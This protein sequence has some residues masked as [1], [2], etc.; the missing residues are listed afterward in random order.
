MRMRACLLVLLTPGQ[1][2]HLLFLFRAVAMTVAVAVPAVRPAVRW[3]VPAGLLRIQ[4]CLV[5]N[6]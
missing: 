6:Q 4:C 2:P 5:H 1:L 3:R